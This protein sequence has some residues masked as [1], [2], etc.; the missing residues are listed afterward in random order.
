M[1][2]DPVL[3]II[4]VAIS[5]LVGF[6][7]RKRAVGFAGIFTCSLVVSP[8]VVALVLLVSAPRVTEPE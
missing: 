3:L 4:Y 6:I 8:I 5:A 2:F 7:G 1:V